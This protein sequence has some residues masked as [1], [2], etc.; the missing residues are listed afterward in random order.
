ML[1]GRTLDDSITTLIAFPELYRR[2][3]SVSI[4]FPER[5]LLWEQCMRPALIESHPQDVVNLPRT[6]NR[7]KTVGGNMQHIWQTTLIPLDPHRQQ[8]LDR[9]TE[10]MATRQ[11]FTGWFFIHIMV[12]DADPHNPMNAEERET[13]WTSMI[14]GLHI[15]ED[16][17]KWFTQ[18]WCRVE[19]PNH[20][21][22]LKP[23]GHGTLVRALLPNLDE[24][25]IQSLL[26]K[27]T[28]TSLSYNCFGHSCLKINC[29]QDNNVFAPQTI[30][31]SPA[32]SSLGQ[33]HFMPNA[34]LPQKIEH[35]R[36]KIEKLLKNLQKEPFVSSL[37]NEP[38][39]TLV[40]PIQSAKTVFSNMDMIQ[41][42]FDIIPRVTMM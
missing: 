39:V 5:K 3:G 21:P 35:T 36:T 33:V 1:F 16:L 13:A 25:C 12:N 31:L 29:V 37:F 20:I 14:E 30:I 19:V 7:L 6:L 38:T 11:I 4:G 42:V 32:T 28:S 9:F 24:D 17:S 34:L 8:F 26:S 23:E 22:R 15:G 10:L 27:H 18:V 2:D 41:E 40:T